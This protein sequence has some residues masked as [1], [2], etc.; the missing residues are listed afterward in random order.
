LGSRVLH[1]P[2]YRKFVATL[3]TWRQDAQLTQRQLAA[4][5]KKPASYVAKSELGERRIDPVEMV[6]W[7][8]ACGV[9]P[10]EA[11]RAVERDV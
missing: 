7:C 6:L 4:K 1:H 9:K 2:G 5:L 8:R 10:A 3:R 11:I